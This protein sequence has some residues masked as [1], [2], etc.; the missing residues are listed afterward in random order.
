MDPNLIILIGAFFAG[1]MLY[2]S[3]GHGGASA[4][5]LA[6]GLLSVSPESLRPTALALNVIVS[7][8]ATVVFL[9]KG[10]FS[11]SLF[12]PCVLASMPLAFVGARIELFP[13]LFFILL[14][15]ALATA[16][17]RLCFPPKVSSRPV[18]AAPL[19]RLAIAGGGIGFI[20][21]L[22]GIGGGVFLTPLLILCRWATPHTAAAVSAPFVLV[23]SLAGLGGLGWE[24]FTPHSG[25]PLLMASVVIGGLLG[26]RLASRTKRPELLKRTLGIVLLLAAAK[27]VA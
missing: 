2:S 12:F 24:K 11:A 19:C 7:F 25:L 22:V 13:T 8:I 21:G 18:E 4:Y 3:V 5:L 1:S 15:L 27:L 9:R 10:H 6:M 20:S 23:N 26:S 17:M 14:A 16:G